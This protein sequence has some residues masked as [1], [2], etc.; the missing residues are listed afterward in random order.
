[1]KQNYL[2]FYLEEK[3]TVRSY[4]R[5]SCF[6]AIFAI[7]IYKLFQTYASVIISYSYHHELHA[8]HKMDLE[9]I[10]QDASKSLVVIASVIFRKLW[11]NIY[12]AL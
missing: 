12:V 9:S 11:S 5:E 6:K 1:M 4:V 8:M 2:H 10:S 3:D 7:S